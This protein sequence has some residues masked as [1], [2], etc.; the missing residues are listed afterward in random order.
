MSLRLK[1]ILGVAAIEA[2]L[3]ALLVTTVLNFMRS[4]SEQALIQ[5]AETASALFATTTKDAVLS[6]DLASLDAFTLEALKNP[7][8]VYARVV[9][10][11]GSVFAEAGDAEALTRPFESDATLEGVTDGVFDQ[12]AAIEE[13]GVTYGQVQLGLSTDSIAVA[14]AEARKLAGSIAL[15]EM[16]L[17]ALFSFFLGTYLTHQLKAL[18][19]GA[20][21]I[22]EGE[23]EVDVPVRGRDEV[24]DVAV[25]FNAMVGNLRETR[26]RRDQYDRELEELN[27]TLEDRVARRTLSLQEKNDELSDAYETIK[28]AQAQLLQSEK[29][30]S[31]GQL[32][33][34]VA[35]E[36]N[37]PV[38]FINSNLETLRDY[39]VLYQGLIARYA[40]LAQL[41]DADARAALAADIATLEDDEDFDFVNDDIRSLLSDSIE[42][43]KRVR[44]IV[45]GMKNFSHADSTE[46]EWVDVNA[47]VDS[48]LKVAANELKYKCEVITSLADIPA[49]HCNA[50]QLN[51]V[52]LNLIVNASHAIEERGA[53]TVTTEHQGDAV[54]IAIA[55]TGTG[56][57]QAHLDKLFEPFFTTKPV[58]Q[59]T[60][61]G[62]AIVY[63]IVTDHGGEISVD[64]E[65]GRGTTF[66]IRLPIQAGASEPVAA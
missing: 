21:Q 4:D 42:G 66:T 29:M 24:A 8:M 60:G 11:D 61:L 6:F 22:S 28:S 5:R 19:R 56:I 39:I 14:L 57:E 35:H 27:R 12:S 55:D 3:L 15:A 32:A 54:S 16:G 41:D 9:G 37:N 48:A 64:S 18:H 31:V 2:V 52:V 65:L 47:C 40:E 13:G 30:A 36:I 63:G 43:A 1:T 59:G 25:A 23:L 62:L 38:G 51:Q 50:G 58:G 10:S 20:Q 7:G 34:G 53:I 49:V 17:V 26:K 33:A 45:Q 46:R 44:E